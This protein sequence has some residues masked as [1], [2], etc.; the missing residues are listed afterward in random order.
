MRAEDPR[1]RR[2]S[3]VPGLRETADPAG[4]FRSLRPDQ[5]GSAD[6]SYGAVSCRITAEGCGQR[7]LAA[8]GPPVSPSGPTPTPGWRP[9]SATCSSVIRAAGRPRSCGT[10]CWTCCRTRRPCHAGL[11]GSAT[12]CRY[13]CRSI[14]SRRGAPH[15][16]VRARHWPRH[17]GRGLSRTMPG[18]QQETLVT[19]RQLDQ[20]PQ[21]KVRFHGQETR[22]GMSTAVSCCARCPEA[23]R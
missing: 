15:M 22:P 3:R 5:P 14:S 11:S 16:T 7:R 23:S 21:L 6:I 13:G 2:E 19:Q 17:S 4:A 18:S 1:G 20:V 10:S 9:G 8:S 12:G